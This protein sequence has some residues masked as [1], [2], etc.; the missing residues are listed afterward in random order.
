[1]EAIEK[2]SQSDQTILRRSVCSTPLEFLSTFGY[3]SRFYRDAPSEMDEER[4]ERLGIRAGLDKSAVMEGSGPIGP[5]VSRE[6]FLCL[7]V[8]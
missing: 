5:R 3:S 2:H 1:M 7:F 8:P 6:I 4:Q